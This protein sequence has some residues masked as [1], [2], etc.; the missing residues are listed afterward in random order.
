MCDDEDNNSAEEVYSE[1]R[2]DTLDFSKVVGAHDN[3]SDNMA[4]SSNLV[5]PGDVVE[6]S[7]MT[8]GEPIKRNEVVTIVDTARDT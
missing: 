5:C 7:N 6:Y 3:L 4:C 1:W 2:K 8:G